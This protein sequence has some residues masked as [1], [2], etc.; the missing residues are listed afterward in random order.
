MWWTIRGAT[1]EPWKVAHEVTGGDSSQSALLT[2]GRSRPNC[3]GMR[4]SRR[5]VRTSNAHSLKRDA[6]V[7][8]RPR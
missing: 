5:N 2:Y 3:G 6:R 8:L 7:S 4:L 1:L